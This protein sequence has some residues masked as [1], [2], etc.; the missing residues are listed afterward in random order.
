MYCPACGID[1]V[2]GLKYCKR[3]GVN[4]TA[5]IDGAHSKNPPS[6]LIIAV[7][8]FIGAVFMTG[9][10]MP[11]LITKEL[12]NRGFSQSYQMALFIIEFGVTL[13]VVGMLVQF[14]F[15]LIGSNQHT[16]KPARAVEPGRI[17]APQPQI[18][19]PQIPMASVTENTTRS[20]ERRVY[21][22]VRT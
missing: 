14:L 3:C 13:A 2:D 1:S 19:E 11:F 8:V 22:N 6:A 20:F 17:D 12:A 15:R 9:L 7:L 4:L 21:D 10:T 16:D 5:T 18:A